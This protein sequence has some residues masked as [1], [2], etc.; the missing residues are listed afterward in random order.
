[1]WRHHSGLAAVPFPRPRQR[2]G[3]ATPDRRERRHRAGAG[4]ATRR[5]KRIPLLH[6][7]Q[8]RADVRHLPRT[9]SAADRRGCGRK[10]P[11]GPAVHHLRRERLHKLPAVTVSARTA[12]IDENPTQSLEP[13]RD[14]LGTRAPAAP[15]SIAPIN[16]S[17][18]QTRI[19]KLKKPLE[20][21][22]VP[23]DGAMGTMIQR[24]KLDEE[25]FRGDRF[26]DYGRDLK[27]KQRPAGAHAAGYDH[28]DSSPIPRSRRRHHRDQHVQ[29]HR[30]LAS[31]LRHGGA[32]AGDELSRSKDRE[33]RRRTSTPRDTGKPRMRGAEHWAPPAAC[34]RSRRM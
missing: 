12:H 30:D 13:A 7:E 24:Q 28:R 31:R 9:G 2:R 3:N 25:A 23:L 4:P 14:G 5:R 18:R 20:E 34:A 16:E 11:P 6:T 8:G 32:G 27:G 1:M 17:E 19:R 29:L 10:P 33:A 21:R 15:F 26:R 22:I